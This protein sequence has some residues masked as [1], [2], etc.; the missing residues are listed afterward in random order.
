[1][2]EA[3]G[4]PAAL[5]RFVDRAHAL[6]LAVCLDVVYNHLGPEGNYLAELGPYFTTVTARSGATAST[7]TAPRPDRSERS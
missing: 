6:G 1:M 7:T 4:G 3:Y 2:H 5:Q